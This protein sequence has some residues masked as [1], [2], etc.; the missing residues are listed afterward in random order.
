MNTDTKP[1]RVYR[2]ED[3]F[4]LDT[5][6]TVLL[7]AIRPEPTSKT[8]GPRH[9]APVNWSRIRHRITVVTLVIGVTCA[10]Y[11]G[12]HML[13]PHEQ[14]PSTDP[15]WVWA[16]LGILWAVAVIP[17]A[18]EMSGLLMWRPPLA[19]PRPIRNLVCWRIVSRG[20]NVEALRETITACRR[21]MQRTPLFPYVIEVVIDTGTS[22]DGLPVPGADLRYLRVPKQYSTVNGTRNKARALNYALWASPIPDDAWIVHLDEESRPL[23]SGITGIAAA[24]H[25]EEASGKLRIGQGTITYHRDWANHPFFTLA[26]CIRTG[27]DLGRLY[28]SMKVGV[29]LFG[30]HGSFIVVR[31]DVERALGFDVGPKGSLTEDAWWGTIAMDQGYRCRWVEGHVAEQCTFS[32]R[33]FLKQRR[34]WFSGMAC[35]ALR[36][37]VSWKWR[38]L[39]GISMVTWASA[40]IAWIYTIAHFVA[41][42]YCPPEI[43][44]MANI[45]LAVYIT[46]TIIG[47]GVNME[48]HGIR[49]PLLKLRWLATWIACLPVFS[50]MEATAVAY[51]LVSPA[52]TFD[53]VR[54]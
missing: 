18:C 40:P 54:K 26:D 38:A 52:K 5:E 35:T 50:F 43:R 34:R 3:W 19:Q 49:H 15:G 39:L 6:P 46:T 11:I 44:A 32:V 47:L 4:S 20:L 14:L 37:P 45:S 24:I 27:S 28:L 12:Q 33:D 30:L 8:P 13:W 1:L 31:N 22:T 53:V 23:R 48:E 42:G 21:E 29:P 36:A 41:G 10:L 51:A 9:A 2:E 25:E 7:P 16:W 17:A